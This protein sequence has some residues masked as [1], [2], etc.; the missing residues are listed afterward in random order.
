MEMAMLLAMNGGNY[1]LYE[2]SKD[3]QSRDELSNVETYLRL[4]KKKFTIDPQCLRV[5]T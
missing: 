5:E 4:L 3:K 1:E 2:L